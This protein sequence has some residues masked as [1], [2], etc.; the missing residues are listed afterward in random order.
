M[1]LL[2]LVIIGANLAFYFYDR[3]R[4]QRIERDAD[5]A[6]AEARRNQTPQS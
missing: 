1:W 6:L 5:E 4:I 2:M 3:A